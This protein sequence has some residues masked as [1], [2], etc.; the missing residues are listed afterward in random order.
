MKASAKTKSGNYKASEV[1]KENPP[2][3]RPNMPMGDEEMECGSVDPLGIYLI[4]H[5][6]FHSGVSIVTIL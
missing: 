3:T 5:I 2:S 1:R 4:E 6:M